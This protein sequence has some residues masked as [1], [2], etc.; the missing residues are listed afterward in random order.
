[1]RGRARGRG[2][3][4]ERVCREV[5]PACGAP[6]RDDSVRGF[7]DDG[8]EGGVRALAS[9]MCDRMLSAGVARR[10]LA[11]RSGVDAARAVGARVLHADAAARALRAK[12]V[13][14][15]HFTGSAVVCT[16]CFFG[17]S[18]GSSPVVRSASSCSA[19]NPETTASTLALITPS[20]FTF[21]IVGS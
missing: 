12:S 19:V 17:R 15:D 14:V 16:S 20:T 2:G 7:V 13:L 6:T 4:R 9:A 3:L 10:R 5:P 11:F 18:P 21:T 1:M 8:D